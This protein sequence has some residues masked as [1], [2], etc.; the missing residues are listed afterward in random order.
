MEQLQDLYI[1]VVEMAL[2]KRAVG[3]QVC[4]NLTP[5]HTGAV[6]ND[7]TAAVNAARTGDRTDMDRRPKIPRLV[8]LH[9]RG[10]GPLLT[11]SKPKEYV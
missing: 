1:P 6:Y 11:T 7:L 10:L 8:T 5:E 9:W 3:V 2:D 4:K